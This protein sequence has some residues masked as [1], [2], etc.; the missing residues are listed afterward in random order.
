VWLD[1]LEASCQRSGSDGAATLFILQGSLYPN[2]VEA[3]QE[4]EE[5]GWTGMACLSVRCLNPFPEEK[6]FSWFDKA[7]RI[8]V[9]DRSNSFGS[10][11]PLAS[12]VF[13]ALARFDSYNGVA[14]RR[15]LRTLVGGLGGRE[16]SVK[17]MREILLS[18]HLLFH[19]PEPWESALIERW[20]DED[21]TLRVLL[22]DA[23]ALDTRNT[24]RH[25]RVPQQWRPAAAEQRE[26]QEQ[27]GQFRRLLTA[28]N[29]A[30]LLAN[31]H[32]VEFIAP[33]EVLQE[34]T[35]LQQIVLTL[36]IRL[37]RHAIETGQSTWRHPLVLLHYSQ[38]SAD[39]E[40]AK[41]VLSREMQAGRLPARLA[42]SYLQPSGSTVPEQEAGFL[43][44]V[45]PSAD[46]A[47][48]S[49]C[50]V[51][52]SGLPT[53]TTTSQQLVSASEPQSPGPMVK[54]DEGLP[55]LVVDAQETGRIEALL[56]AMVV[57]QGEEPLYYNPEDYENELLQRLEEEPQ[58]PLYRARDR[59]PA[60][61]VDELLWN[62]RC[63][64]RDVIDRTLQREILTQHHATELRELFADDG[65]NRLRALAE[66]LRAELAEEPP[67]KQKKTIM[68]EMERYL[69][70]RC[71]PE[72]SK[73]P[74][75]Y[76]EYFRN[77]VAPP[78]AAGESS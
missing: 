42:A 68:E 50:G 51:P 2:A 60:Q 61:Q 18:T 71:L 26:Y 4:L 29:Y 6:F 40:L 21:A 67:E 8:V 48:P 70:D 63:C 44:G 76:L 22:T 73:T 30:Q 3:L 38:D 17:E 34:T 19:P 20:L 16:I 37:A 33:R 65:L 57:R 23:A 9:L 1:E 27:L 54:P 24:N 53:M 75:F 13:T 52:G 56:T 36:E 74:L 31:Y 55:R 25:T 58:S 39:H 11:P 49:A 46:S 43:T 47:A 7:E 10:V 14:V 28:K 69:R 62:Y 64:Y 5:A 59:W 78:L 32:Q 45:E 72:Y 66:R 35:L 41:P 15:R 77:W 12:R